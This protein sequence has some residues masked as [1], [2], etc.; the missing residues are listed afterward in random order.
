MTL[1]LCLHILLNADRVQSYLA[2]CLILNGLLAL[3]ALCTNVSKVGSAPG[4]HIT[5]S[6]AEGMQTKQ[7]PGN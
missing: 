5:Y 2:D 6:S 3:S 7:Q 4:H 1:T